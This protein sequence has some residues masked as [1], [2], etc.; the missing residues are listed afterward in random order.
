MKEKREGER[1]GGR[2]KG[3]NK[4][5]INECYLGQGGSLESKPWL[6]RVFLYIWAFGEVGVKIILV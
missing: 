4:A 2:E 3:K 6:T 5:Y 1:Q